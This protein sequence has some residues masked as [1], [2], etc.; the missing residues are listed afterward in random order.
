MPHQHAWAGILFIPA[1]PFGSTLENVS[2][3]TAAH[4][5]GSSSL[6]WQHPARPQSPLYTMVPPSRHAEIHTLT[7][8]QRKYTN[9]CCW[10]TWEKTHPPI[11]S[12]AHDGLSCEGPFHLWTH[13]L[14]LFFLRLPC[15]QVT[16]FTFRWDIGLKFTP[17]SGEVTYAINYNFSCTMEILVKSHL[18]AWAVGIYRLTDT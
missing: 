17:T 14:V 15:C 9:I 13:P 12:W 1:C 11:C 7:H 6:S 8:S 4:T 10:H 18:F 16:V 3:H 5:G 2:C